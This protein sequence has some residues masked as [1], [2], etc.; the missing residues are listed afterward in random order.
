MKT[1]LFV[2]KQS[3]G[4]FSV[5]DQSVSTGTRFYVGSTE[6]NAGNT[7]G[8]GRNPDAPFATL[9]YALSSDV[10]T[11]SKGD[12]IYLMPGHA[13]SIAAASGC[14]LDIAGVQVIG[15]GTGS[16]IPTFTLGTDVGATIDITAPNCVLRN[17]KIVSA[18]ADIAA[19]V[20]IGALG[21]GYW[22]DGCI[23]KDGGAAN[24]E[25]VSGITVTAA[26]DRGKITNCRFH[27]VAAGNNNQ[28]ILLG[29][30]SGCRIENNVIIGDYD[31]ACISIPA[32]ATNLIIR[33]NTLCNASTDAIAA[34][35]MH[36]SCEGVCAWNVYS[37]N[38]N[39]QVPVTAACTSMAFGGN[40]GSDLLGVS[41]MIAPAVAAI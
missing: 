9:S 10:C 27:T 34:L 39:G 16:L 26:A 30:V 38:L 6:T 14:L 7:A 1:S 12:I 32:A 13:E 17:V 21:D 3:G 36:T 24:L 4:M 29:A 8:K 2:E 35:A 20:T 23:F 41:G 19:G 11:A 15:L 18:L 40:Y 37:A 25:M 31:V 22:I 5:Q 28:A 33:H